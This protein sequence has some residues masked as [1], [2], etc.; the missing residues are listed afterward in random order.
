MPKIGKKIPLNY[1]GF[2]LFLV[3]T[4]EVFIINN[5][6]NKQL[7]ILAFTFTS[8]NAANFKL[9]NDTFGTYEGDLILRH[10]HD[11]CKSCIEQDELICRF[12]SDNFDLLLKTNSQ[13]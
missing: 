13:D 6:N 8:L 3:V 2:Y 10:I 12:F 11:V 7:S 9:F 4:E 1:S 5:R